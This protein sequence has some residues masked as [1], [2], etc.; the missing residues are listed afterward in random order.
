MDGADPSPLPS[1]LAAAHVERFP[2]SA[3]T[4]TTSASGSVTS[5]SVSLSA[6]SPVG[7]ATMV[8]DVVP[9]S[10]GFVG[11]QPITILFNPYLRDDP[12]Y[13]DDAVE[14]GEYLEQTQVLWPCP[15][16]AHAL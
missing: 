5:V 6:S 13:M 12:T 10:G 4:Y 8:C 2:A 15:R 16:P 7:S 11:R 14:R 1:I 9:A 3:A